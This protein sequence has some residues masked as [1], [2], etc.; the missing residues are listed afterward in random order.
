MKLIQ[1]FAV[2]VCVAGCVAPPPPAPQVV[3]AAPNEET[4][5]TSGAGLREADFVRIAGRIEP[6]AERM[7]QEADA[8]NQCDFLIV[9]DDRAN[10]PPNAYQFITKNGR[11]VL[12][13][14]IPLLDEVQND[15]ELAFVIGHEAAHHVAGH[16]QQQSE[17]AYQ[18]AM[19]GSLTAT[20]FGADAEAIEAARDIG[21]FVGSRQF[22]KNH[23]IEADKLGA[24]IALEA[25]FD[26][27]VGVGYFTR[28]PDPGQQFLGSHPSNS[29]R[30]QAV[31]TAIS[32][33]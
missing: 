25:G 20:I 3:E 19:L 21:A 10:Q 29:E 22:S 33:A 2:S 5:R 7:C 31:Q 16:I 27:R 26:P 14:T 4:V 18:G 32:G 17:T 13:V 1:V 11:P 24:L 30:I 6:V 8:F 15:D 23:E 28:I 9:M 12:A